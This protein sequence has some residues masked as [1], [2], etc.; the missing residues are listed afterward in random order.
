MDDQTSGEHQPACPADEGDE[1]TCAEDVR[2]GLL[3]FF[4]ALEAEPAEEPAAPDE[5]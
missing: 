1:M 3:N 4:A 2:R 5:D